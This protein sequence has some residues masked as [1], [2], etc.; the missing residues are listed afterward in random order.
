[1]FSEAPNLVLG[2]F[3]EG[4]RISSFQ[5]LQ[6]IWCPDMKKGRPRAGHVLCTLIYPIKVQKN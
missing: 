3:L 2:A 4:S 6:L 5:D 1:M